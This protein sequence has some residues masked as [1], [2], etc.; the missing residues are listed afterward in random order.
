M[1]PVTLAHISDLH[2]S[3]HYRRSNIRH[4]K[5][6]LDFLL[7]QKVDHILVTGD[8]TADAKPKDFQLARN[9]FKSYGLL[10]PVKMSVVIGNHDVFGGV[11]MAEDILEFPRRCRKTNYLKKV[12]EFKKYFHELFEDS[13]GASKSDPF[14]YFKSIGD[15]LV[16]G[17]NSIAEYSTMKNPVGSNGKVSRT[18]LQQLEALL[19]TGRVKNRWKIV[20][21]HH[22]FNKTKISLTGTMQS[23]WGA[24]EHQTMKLRGKKELLSLFKKYSIHLVVHGHQHENMEYTKK[25]IRFLNA[26]GSVLNQTPDNLYI[27][28]L[29]LH[30]GGIDVHRHELTSNHRLL[31]RRIAPP[32]PTE[33]SASIAV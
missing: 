15:L 16:I 17:L 22:H 2:L 27:N 30:D 5:Q 26:G 4:V 10:D 24:I 21:I 19:S 28:L 29:T 3:P 14:P 23:I 11:H 13:V 18:Q 7:Q 20:L 25:G 9:I 1:K 8:I 12:H 32:E 6:V 31:L 33:V